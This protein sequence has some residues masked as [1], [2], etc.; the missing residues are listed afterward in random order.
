MIIYIWKIIHG[1]VPDVGLTYAPTNN[2][3]TIRLHLPQLKGP[4]HVQNLMENSLLYHGARLYNL[5]PDKLRRTT[6]PDNKV[7]PLDSFKR[8]LDKFL[9]RIPDEP[10]P[11]KGGR[12]RSAT[13]NSIL[14]QLA[15]LMPY[16]K[17][18]T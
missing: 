13:T 18:K 16:K 6:H 17:T 4:A 2:N 8:K 5:L 7:I 1:L 14:H 15:Y 10:G 9:W 3:N 12:G 11:I